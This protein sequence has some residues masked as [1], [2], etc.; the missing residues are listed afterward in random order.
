MALERTSDAMTFSTF[1][2]RK[3][4]AMARLTEIDPNYSSLGLLGKLHTPQ[5][6]A[7]TV[8]SIAS[9]ALEQTSGEPYL[10]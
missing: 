9:P 3:A 6:P 8:T 1:L 7:W 10:S 5:A 4:T 2:R